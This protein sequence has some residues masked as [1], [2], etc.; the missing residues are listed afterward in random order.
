MYGVNIPLAEVSQVDT[1]AWHEVPAISY[2]TNGFAFSNVNRGY[3]K[4]TDGDI[5]HMSVHCGLSPVIRLVD[6]NGAVYYINR[7]EAAETR[8]IFKEIKN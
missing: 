6:R 7:K 5:I 1:I 3:F 4:T 2:R 8:E